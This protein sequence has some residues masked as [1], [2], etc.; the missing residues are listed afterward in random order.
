M[1][2]IHSSDLQSFHEIERA[3][4]R[5]FACFGTLC[6]RCARK[7]LREHATGERGN[8]ENWCCCMIDNQVHDHWDTLNPVQCHY[9]RKWYEKLETLPLGRMPGNGPCPALGEQGCRLRKCRPVT[10]TT[11]LCNKM[12]KVLEIW[13]LYIRPTESARQIEELIPLPDILHALYGAGSKRVKR[14]VEEG[15]VASYLNAIHAYR[16]QILAIPEAKRQM[17]IDKVLP[18]A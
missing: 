13:G 12:L 9:D 8:R 1:A 4:W 18:S 15:E 10:C 5:L 16:E 2:R 17:A 11:Q 6:D 7:T 3:L 14:K